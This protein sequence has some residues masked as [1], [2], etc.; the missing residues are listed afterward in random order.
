MVGITLPRAAGFLM[1]KELEYFSRVLENPKRPL[2]A[3]LGGCVLLLL[4]RC[5]SEAFADEL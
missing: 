1:K 2:L 4:E 5:A 3:I